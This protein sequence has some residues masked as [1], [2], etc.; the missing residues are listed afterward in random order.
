MTG[1]EEYLVLGYADALS[2]LT[3]TGGARGQTGS[4]DLKQM[5]PCRLPF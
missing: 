3:G 2:I 4:I 1:R 5:V